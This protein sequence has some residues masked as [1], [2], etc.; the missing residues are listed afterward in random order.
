MTKEMT[1][2]FVVSDDTNPDDLYRV[3]REDMEW[4]YDYHVPMINVHIK[5]LKVPPERVVYAFG[6]RQSDIYFEILIDINDDETMCR[7]LDEYRATDSDG[8]NDV[9][10]VEF[11]R[12]KKYIV[13]RVKVKKEFYF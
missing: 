8:Y 2:T 13:D 12:D 3:I 4:D 1:V 9:D 5:E 6:D 11:L 10:F 7:L